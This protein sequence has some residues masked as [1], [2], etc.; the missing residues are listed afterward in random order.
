MR[1]KATVFLMVWTLVAALPVSIA[2]AQQPS[3]DD[4]LRALK[5]NPVPSIENA[6]PATRSLRGI[7]VV[8]S[9]Q[10]KTPSIDLYINFKLDSAELE[11][12]A[13]L[14][15][16]SLG[17]ALR[18]P[19]LKESKIMIVG[20]TD[21]TGGD[22]YNMQLSQRRA[23]AVRKLLVGAFDID[24]VRL[25]AVGRGKSELKDPSRPGDGINRR[26]EIRNVTGK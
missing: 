18:D 7:Q 6:G 20:H 5:P 12:E 26:V 14:A 15:L 1:A 19:Q 25:Q 16:R 22:D 9:E 23:D 24:S 13:L 3:S 11:G 8:P 10:Q 2:S 21:A 17:T 4:I